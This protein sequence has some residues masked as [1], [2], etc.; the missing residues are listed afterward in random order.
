[1]ANWK[2]LA[3]FM[4]HDEQIDLGQKVL[5]QFLLT[6]D[7][8]LSQQ[9]GYWVLWGASA[10]ISLETLPIDP[11]RDGRCFVL[12]SHWTIYYPVQPLDT[13]RAANRLFRFYIGA[14]ETNAWI[15][16]GRR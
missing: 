5:D 4:S 16:Y 14:E 12:D 6:G 1:M 2:I 7:K 9:R 11:V 10:E 8:L 13:R 15:I 3:S